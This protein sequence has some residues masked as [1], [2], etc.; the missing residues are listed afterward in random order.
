[1]IKI[2]SHYIFLKCCQKHKLELEDSFCVSDFKSVFLECLI[3]ITCHRSAGIQLEVKIWA[4]KH[5][6]RVLNA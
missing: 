5:C 4:N 1:M 6:V 2:P 3:G